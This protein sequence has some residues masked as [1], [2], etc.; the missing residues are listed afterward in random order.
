MVEKE[1]NIITFKVGERGVRAMTGFR[2]VHSE[3]HEDIGTDAL[4]SL[5]LSIFDEKR[6]E[7]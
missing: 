6:Y 7:I 4:A 3:I 5:V 1:G 2:D